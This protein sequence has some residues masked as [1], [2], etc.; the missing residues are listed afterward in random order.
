MKSSSLE[1]HPEGDRTLLFTGV[2]TQLQ[3]KLSLNRLWVTFKPGLAHPE[4][5]GGTWGAQCA[6]VS[7]WTFFRSPC[8]RTDPSK[9]RDPCPFRRKNDGRNGNQVWK[10]TDG[11]PR[12][13][14]IPKD[15]LGDSNSVAPYS[16]PS[17][18]PYPLAPKSQIHAVGI[19]GELRILIPVSSKAK[20][21]PGAANP[22]AMEK[23]LRS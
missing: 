20:D 10:F 8:A 9:V 2:W 21:L 12:D 4:G 22:R 11:R 6:V 7:A 18:V 17:V 23:P 13:V 19:A 5:C 1:I 16:L 15:E 14:T 3:L